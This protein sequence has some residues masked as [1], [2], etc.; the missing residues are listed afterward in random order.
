MLTQTVLSLDWRPRLGHIKHWCSSS[1]WLYLAVYSGWMDG[2][3]L[4]PDWRS[5]EPKTCRLL[6]G[7]LV[8][9][10]VQ[11]VFRLCIID[12]G[13]HLTT[14]VKSQKTLSRVS[15]RCLAEQ[16][17]HVSLSRLGLVCWPRSPLACVSSDQSKPSIIVGICRVVQ[18]RGSPH[19][20]TLSQNSRVGLW[21]G[22]RRM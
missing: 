22:R 2:W 5:R 13:I 12:P 21:C 10:E 14:E 6:T 8:R 4:S 16:C 1:T 19:R 15:K 7:T 17:W 11:A 3:I 18:R 9:T 20:L